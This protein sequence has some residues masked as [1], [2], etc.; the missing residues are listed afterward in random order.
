MLTLACLASSRD[1]HRL[2]AS[3]ADV[4][5]WHFPSLPQ[6][7][8]VALHMG[9]RGRGGGEERS[10]S[11]RG[12]RSLS[13]LV[14]VYRFGSSHKQNYDTIMDPKTFFLCRIDLRIGSAVQF[15]GFEVAGC[16]R[17]PGPSQDIYHYRASGLP[18][19]SSQ[20]FSQAAAHQ[21]CCDSSC[22]KDNTFY[23]LIRWLFDLGVL[24]GR[25]EN[26]NARFGWLIISTHQ[27][28]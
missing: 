28:E 13:L 27:H 2:A 6:R 7:V 17:A 9:G 20:D 14:Y 26:W 10:A 15:R 21:R 22:L 11:G 25:D 18:D 16:L 8:F 3:H 4:A 12:S 5:S 1:I 23:T 19:K 24:H